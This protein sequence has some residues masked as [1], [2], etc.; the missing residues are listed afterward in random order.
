MLMWISGQQMAQHGF[1]L[2]YFGINKT[3]YQEKQI[4]SSCLWN[5]FYIMSEHTIDEFFYIQKA[6]GVFHLHKLTTR[7]ADN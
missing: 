5:Y 7:Q 6:S 3:E 2:R 1:R 4:R